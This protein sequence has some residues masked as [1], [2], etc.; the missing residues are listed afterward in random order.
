MQIKHV[1]SKNREIPYQNSFVR[2]S[3]TADGVLKHLIYF[4]GLNK[5]HYTCAALD[6]SLELSGKGI[7]KCWASEL[8]TAASCFQAPIPMP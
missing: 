5:K 2:E 8:I 4:L 1:K 6:I 7:E 3:I